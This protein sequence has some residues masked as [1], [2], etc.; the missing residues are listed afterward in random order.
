MTF[1][2]TWLL[3]CMGIVLLAVA[4]YAMLLGISMGK[5]GKTDKEKHDLART[6]D[7]W[8][9]KIF[10]GLYVLIVSTYFYCVYAYA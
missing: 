10:I 7:S 6:I 4:E 3:L 9:M 8:A 1:M 2:D 5:G